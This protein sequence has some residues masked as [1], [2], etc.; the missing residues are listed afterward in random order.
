MTGGPTA[1]QWTFGDGTS[2]P[3]QNPDWETNVVAAEVTL[4][5]RRGDDADSVTKVISTY[6]C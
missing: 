1:W 6:E 4:T 3:E 2:S 5:V